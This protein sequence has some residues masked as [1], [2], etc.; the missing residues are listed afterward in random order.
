MGR[1][2][3][4]RFNLAPTPKLARRRVAP[5]EILGPLLVLAGCGILIWAACFWVAYVLLG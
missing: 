2:V 4:P 3:T 5:T 1:M